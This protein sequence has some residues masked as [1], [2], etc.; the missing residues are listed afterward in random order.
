MF[1][2][3]NLSGRVVQLVVDAF[4]RSIREVFGDR[5]Y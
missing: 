2:A 5:N 3:K 1:S 4:R